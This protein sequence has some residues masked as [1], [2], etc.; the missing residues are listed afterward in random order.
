MGFWKLVSLTVFRSSFLLF[1]TFH[2]TLGQYIVGEE[3]VIL[4]FGRTK[5]KKE[6]INTVESHSLIK[7][8]KRTSC[9][10]PTN[11]LDKA[12]LESGLSIFI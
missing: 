12:N 9:L 10:H 6:V 8:I 5:Q 1:V 3:A 4:S 7:Q 2:I 11:E